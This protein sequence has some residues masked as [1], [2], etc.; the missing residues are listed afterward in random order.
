M[1]ANHHFREAYRSQD[2]AYASMRP[3]GLEAKIRSFYTWKNFV[4][5]FFYTLQTTIN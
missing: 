2:P 1:A 3:C 5:T 4:E